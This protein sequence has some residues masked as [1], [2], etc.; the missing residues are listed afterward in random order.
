MENEKPLSP[1]ESLQ[2]IQTMIS[3]TK[4]AVADNSFYFLF[5]GWLVF[6][7]CMGSFI[8]KVYFHSPY[9]SYVWFLM[10]VGGVISGIYSA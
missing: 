9:E 7:C 8:L 2:L 1:E 4:D 10:P 5:W 6:G 3:K